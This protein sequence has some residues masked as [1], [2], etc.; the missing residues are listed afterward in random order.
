MHMQAC[1]EH[2]PCPRVPCSNSGSGGNGATAGALALLDRLIVGETVSNAELVSARGALAQAECTMGGTRNAEASGPP[3]CD[4][5]QQLQMLS[6]DANVKRSI[7]MML[8]D[9]R[10]STLPMSGGWM[11][12]GNGVDGQ[13]RNH[14]AQVMGECLDVRYCTHRGAALHT[15]HHT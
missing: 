13:W 15:P 3:T 6:G 1:P 12:W 14:A 5:L 8:M 4:L 9:I 7:A 10:E 2:M 11:A